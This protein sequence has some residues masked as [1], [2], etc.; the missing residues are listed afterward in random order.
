MKAFVDMEELKYRQ[1][2][3]A[4]LYRSET[5]SFVACC[6]MRRTYWSLNNSRGRSVGVD[7]N[8]RSGRID[9]RSDPNVALNEDG[10]SSEIF[11]YALWS[12]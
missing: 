4:G 1:E 10:E 8:A 7:D 6:D 5:V 12:R 2:D 11:W 9:E 3:D